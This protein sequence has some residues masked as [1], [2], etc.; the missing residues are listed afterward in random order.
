M[1][2]IPVQASRR[3]AVQSGSKGGTAFGMMFVGFLRGQ[4]FNIYSGNLRI[5]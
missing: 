1:V 5:E 3:C 2:A 4:R